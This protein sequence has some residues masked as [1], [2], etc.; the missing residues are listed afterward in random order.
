V[1][2]GPL[3]YTYIVQ[4]LGETVGVVYDLIGNHQHVS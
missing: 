3:F 1:R 2:V 4:I